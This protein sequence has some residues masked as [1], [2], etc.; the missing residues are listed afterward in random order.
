MSG[1]LKVYS[2]VS[3]LLKVEKGR[4]KCVGGRFK[5]GV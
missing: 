1:K 5:P 2:P 4:I 3:E